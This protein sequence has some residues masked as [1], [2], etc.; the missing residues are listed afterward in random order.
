MNSIAHL[1]YIFYVEIFINKNIVWKGNGIKMNR[2]YSQQTIYTLQTVLIDCKVA[3]VIRNLFLK[4]QFI[5]DHNF[6]SL[7]PAYARP[8]LQRS[9]GEVESPWNV[10]NSPC[11]NFKIRES[12]QFK[13][14]VYNN[15]KKSSNILVLHNISLNWNVN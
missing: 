1:S 4:N 14:I 7:F 6:H 10:S 12:L 13:L 3:G 2:I 11:D 15:L 8:Y 9:E 5:W